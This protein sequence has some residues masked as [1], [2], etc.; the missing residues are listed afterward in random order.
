MLFVLTLGFAGRAQLTALQLQEFVTAENKFKTLGLHYPL[1][2]ARFYQ[3]Y[4]YEPAWI[5]IDKSAHCS[6]FF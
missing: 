3:T 5:G 1:L 2:V 4:K 6:I